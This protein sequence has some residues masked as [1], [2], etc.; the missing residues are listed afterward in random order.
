VFVLFHDYYILR[1]LTCM[2]ASLKKIHALLASV[3]R[4]QLITS[5]VKTDYSLT[6]KFQTCT[7]H[8]HPPLNSLTVPSWLAV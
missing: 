4:T 8:I 1:M 3:S 6:L 7:F 2:D 5:G